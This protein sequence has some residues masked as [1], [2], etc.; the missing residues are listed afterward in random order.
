MLRSRWPQ[1]NLR[2][3]GS[4]PSPGPRGG[5]VPVEKQAPSRPLPL[6]VQSGGELPDMG[7][8]TGIPPC[9]GTPCRG[10][11]ATAS[12]EKRSARILRTFHPEI[13]LKSRERFNARGLVRGFGGFASLACRSGPA[14]FGVG[15]K[16]ASRAGMRA[17]HFVGNLTFDGNLLSNYPG[18]FAF[19][20]P[21]NI[22]VTQ[23]RTPR[24]FQ[25]QPRHSHQA[26]WGV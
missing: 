24:W 25:I 22:L 15:Q 2:C 5:L 11:Q 8:K 1:T 4:S 21:A 23:Y 14:G 18:A 26:F 6:R 3:T 9:V 16:R 20:F 17:R 10:S 19:G 7:P 12:A 13:C